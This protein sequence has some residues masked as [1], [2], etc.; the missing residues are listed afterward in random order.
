MAEGIVY[1][2][3]NEAMPG[4]IKIGKTTD[5]LNNRIRQLDGTNMP[6]PFTCFYAAKVSDCDFVEKQL[7]DAFADQRVRLRREFFRLSPERVVAALAIANGKNVTPDE[8]IVDLP[9]DEKALNEARQCRGRFSFDLVGIKAGTVLYS[10]FDSALTC[11]VANHNKVLFEGQETSLSAAAKI[12]AERH[13]Y[14]WA[15]IAG[16]DYW[17]HDGKSLTEIRY[18]MEASAD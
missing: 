1:I 9:E 3:T 4:Y 10:S 17:L 2:L 15:A 8:D 12:A 11:V 7:H 18:E 14:K 6:L 16:P 5:D 13:G